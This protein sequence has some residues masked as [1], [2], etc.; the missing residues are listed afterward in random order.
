MT[1]EGGWRARPRGEEGLTRMILMNFIR[2]F[3]RSFGS[4]CVR[5][6]VRHLPRTM[7]SLLLCHR[8]FIFTVVPRT[9][10][11]L[12]LCHAPSHLYCCAMYHLIFTAVSCTMSSLLLWHTPC[13]LYCCATYYVIFITVPQTMSSLLLCHAPCTFIALPH[14]MSPSL[15]YCQYILIVTPDM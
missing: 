13:H 12:L 15:L 8:P 14:T 9:M 3:S 10:S 5:M 2:Y 7:S 11:S 6:R 4:S 1:R